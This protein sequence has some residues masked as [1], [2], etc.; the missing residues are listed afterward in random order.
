MYVMLVGL[1]P[2]LLTRLIGVFTGLLVYLGISL[3]LQCPMTLV[4]KSE[5]A[6]FFFSK[7]LVFISF[8]LERSVSL[9]IILLLT[10][11]KF[12]SLPF[13]FLGRLDAYF[14]SSMDQDDLLHGPCYGQIFFVTSTRKTK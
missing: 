3:Q 11:P 13:S 6:P 12:C 1:S 7:R 9:Q 14:I 10:M 4:Y 8:C 2:R 5:D